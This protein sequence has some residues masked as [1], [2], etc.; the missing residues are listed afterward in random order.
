MKDFI[1][2]VILRV[3]NLTVAG[4]GF[5]MFTI[6]EPVAGFLFLMI[7]TVIVDIYAEYINNK[8]NNF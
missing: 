4:W 3:L 1:I 6:D 8:H 7:A 2:R 5:R